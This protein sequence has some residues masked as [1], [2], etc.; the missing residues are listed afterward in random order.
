MKKAL[1]SLAL[2]LCSVALSAKPMVFKRIDGGGSGPFKAIAASES[3]LPDFTVYRPENLLEAAGTDGT[4][5]VIVFGNGGCVNTSVGHERFLS[6]LASY[7]YVVVAI[8]PFQPGTN[9]RPMPASVTSTDSYLMFKGLDWI[10]NQARD[11]K[12]EYFG[13]VNVN[14]VASMGMSCGGAQAMYLSCDPRVKTLVMLNSGMGAVTMANASRTNVAAVHCPTVYILGGESDIAFKNGEADYDLIKNVPVAEV[15]LPVGHGGTYAEEFG[16]EFSRMTRTWLDYVFKGHNEGER[17]FKNGD[18]SGFNGW[19][20]RS[21]N[22]DGQQAPRANRDATMEA[23]RN[24]RPTPDKWAKPTGPYKVVME[25]DPTCP[26]HTVYRPE[27]LSKFN[28]KNPLPIIVMSGPG[29]DYD[30]DSYRPF[31]TEVASYDYVVIASGLPVKEGFRAAMGF[32][33]ATSY[34]AALAWAEKENARQ[35]SKYFGKLA[36]EKCAAMG[37]S[38]G[39]FL[40]AQFMNDPRM[41]CLMFWNA[42]G[43]PTGENAARPSCPV[44]YFSADNDMALAGALASYNAVTDVPA[45]FGKCDIPGD[46]HGGTFREVNG[47]PYGKAAVAWL[48]WHLKGQTKYAKNFAPGKAGLFKDARWVETQSKKI[49]K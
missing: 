8:G 36:P 15:N 16:G 41:K 7:G 31:W 47:G 11:E 6:D 34:E 20:A 32:N 23:Y 19:T 27:N 14:Q 33:K 18:L 44:A 21:K 22:F 35:D 12:S 5:P 3:S 39:G 17:L 26:D 42:G 4:L 2:I 46:A 43:T 24:L 45:F 10:C 28:A 13:T 29:C 25:V 49:A 37:Q 48:N 38:C 1:I 30:G 9:P 40:T